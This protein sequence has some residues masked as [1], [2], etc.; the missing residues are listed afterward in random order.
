MDIKISKYQISVLII[1]FILGNYSI[2]NSIKNLGQDFWIVFV[3]GWLLSFLLA[4]IYVKIIVNNSK[5]NFVNIIIDSFGSTIGRIIILLYILYFLYQSS[6]NLRMVSEYYVTVNYLETPIISILILIGFLIFYSLSKGIDT[7]ARTAEILTPIGLILVSF[8]FFFVSSNFDF[9]YL[10][11]IFQIS[12]IT[13]IRYS[14]IV[15]SNTF[16]GLFVFI[17]ISNFVPNKSGIYKTIFIS[18]AISGTFILVLLFRDLLILGPDM[19][20]RNVFP[21]NRTSNFVSNILLEPILSFDI[22]L[23]GSLKVMLYT[24]GLLALLSQLCNIKNYKPFILV[25]ISLLIS[26]SN[27]IIDDITQ[28]TDIVEKSHI[29]LT[30]PFQI[31]IP[32]LILILQKIKRK[33]INSLS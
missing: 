3:L 31:I 8:T 20:E 28:L 30:L 15:L 13:I 27:W 4:F 32:I 6:I 2:F 11:P 25:V 16:G 33:R 19:L 9:K 7:I 22:L 29:Y 26:F 5:T 21:P 24:Y 23:G 14:F 18:I 12:N 17:L 10:K 1:G